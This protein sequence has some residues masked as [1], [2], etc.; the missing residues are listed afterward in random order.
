[1]A[2]VQLKAGNLP[3][4]AELMERNVSPSQSTGKPL[5]RFRVRFESRNAANTD[6]VHDFIQSGQFVQTDVGDP[7][8]E[9][10]WRIGQHSHHYTEGN[11]VTTFEWELEEVEDIKISKLVIAG[12][13]YTPYKYSEEFDSKGRLT[14]ETR[15]ELSETEHEQI[16]QLNPYFPVVRKGINDDPRE[17]RFGQ[18][19]W[20]KKDGKYRMNLILVDRS[21]DQPGDHG[22]LAPR[23]DNIEDTAAVSVITIRSL[24]DKLV[25][26]G[27]LS[28]T[29][30][31]VVSAVNE[32][33]RR[34]E[35]WEFDRVPDLD[36]WLD[37]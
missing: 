19:L 5:I 26:K 15:V 2:L 8:K 28:A 11:P 36:E 29:E 25:E 18:M 32:T 34:K 12:S 16:R 27:I 35:L 22:W 24:L 17:M 30:R 20:S 9:R 4:M 23:L 13:E 31:D 14:I 3:I 1:M 21:K 6:A 33:E 10:R 37:K 7:S